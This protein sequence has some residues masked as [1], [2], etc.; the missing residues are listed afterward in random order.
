MKKFALRIGGIVA[1]LLTL[2]VLWACLKTASRMQASASWPK[3]IGQITA[4]E[5]RDNSIG[6]KEKFKARV[7]YSYQAA[8]GSYSSERIRFADASGSARSTQQA[9]VDK[10]PPG[11]QVDV[12]YDPADPVQAVLEPGGGARRFGLLI[13]PVLIGAVAAWLLVAGF[14]R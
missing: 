8:G 2:L 5:L 11:A 1:S 9:V 14:K 4:S 3:T 10:Y 13:P 7:S 12:Y 6:P